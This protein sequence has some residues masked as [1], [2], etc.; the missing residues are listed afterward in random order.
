[1]ELKIEKLIFGGDGLAR[2]PSTDPERAGKAVFVPF[3]IAGEKVDAKIVEEKPGFARGRVEKILEPSPERV[4][5]G[6]SYFGGCGG[7]Q[8][9]HMSYEAQ[10]RAK[11]EILR[12]TLARTAKI[13]PPDVK[14]HPSPPWHYRNRTRLRVKAEGKFDIG[15][16]RFASHVLLPV[17]EC[18]ISSPLINR[19]LAALWK[20]GE[21]GRVPPGVTEIEFFVNAED[22]EI[23]LE[24]SLAQ[25]SR[26]AVRELGTFAE[27]LRPEL[28][29]LS[30]L[31][32]FVNEGKGGG[33]R[34]I[35]A[36]P[37]L[38]K[39]LGNDLLLY[40]SGGM[41]YQ[42][43]AGSFFQANRYLI[44]TMVSLAGE[45]REG[46]S[47][48]LDLY[49]GV[50]LFAL[51]LSQKFEQV[52]AVEVAPFSFHDL[53]ANSPSN[54]KGHRVSVEQFL[55]ESGDAFDY[56]VL[57]PPRG[58]IGGEAA[59]MLACLRAPHITYISCDPA[60]L[61]RDLKVLIAAGYRMEAIHLLDVFPQTFHIETVSRLILQ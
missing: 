51:P 2:L 21:A 61:A 45:G 37:E 4:Q 3:T 30:G 38:Q 8:Y 5:P 57:D 14:V 24:I 46:S 44:D 26:R 47:H 43:S 31:V 10:L 50:G 19:A 32:P 35:D 20:L 52:T 53:K 9:Q 6:C 23:L 60:T 54:I 16:N 55:V 22:S 58:G 42:V 17:R 39:N 29:E 12:E 56:I 25:G 7:C 34:R 15:Y 33:V 11:S 59:S 49:S 28:P 18:P 1:L 13:D 36:S 40:R 27:A 41:Q 48:A